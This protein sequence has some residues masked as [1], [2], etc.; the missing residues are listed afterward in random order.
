M[1]TNRFF[2]KDDEKEKEVQAKAAERPSQPSQPK[3][4]QPAAAAPA[5]NYAGVR[6]GARGKV[7]T[8][9]AWNQ[10]QNVAKTR[11]AIEETKYSVTERNWDPND[12]LGTRRYNARLARHAA[13][14]YTEQEKAEYRP[15]KLN[16][17]FR[18]V[19][20]NEQAVFFAASMYGKSK[21]QFLKDYAE[22]SG[23]NVQ[24]LYEL[25]DAQEGLFSD[26]LSTKEQLRSLGL[27]TIDGRRI[28]PDVD[29]PDTIVQALKDTADS[30]LQERGIKLL[31]YMTWDKN[32]RFYGYDAYN[33]D[34][35]YRDSAVLT[36]GDYDKWVKDLAGKF[37]PR[38]E[39]L[40]SS[41][42]KY[43]A[44]Y[45]ALAAQGDYI[46]AQ[47]APALEKAFMQQMGVGEMPGIEELR[48]QVNGFL[49][50]EQQAAREAQL[51]AEQD[52]TSD[53]EKKERKGFFDG[54][55]EGLAAWWG[56]NTT[57]ASD[58]EPEEEDEEAEEGADAPTGYAYGGGSSGGGSSSSG[59]AAPTEQEF[60]SRLVADAGANIAQVFAEEANRTL[61]VP[62]FAGEQTEEPI[63][64]PGA[65][66]AA[67]KVSDIAG[68]EWKPEL[69]NAANP[70][71]GS[72]NLVDNLN[73]AMRYVLKGK[74]GLL[75]AD[76]VKAL[77]EWAISSPETKA[78][79]GILDE[80]DPAVR[81]VAAGNRTHMGAVLDSTGRL[82]GF[83][84]Y[85]QK[86]MKMG[87]AQSMDGNGFMPDL[88]DS[89]AAA[90]IDAVNGM[91]S[92][93]LTPEQQA[94]VDGGYTTRGQI[95][96][97]ANPDVLATVQ[98]AFDFADSQ[99]TAML[100]A[101]KLAAE[102]S[103]QEA[104]AATKARL[105][106]GYAAEGDLQ[107]A[108]ANTPIRSAADRSTDKTYVEMA[109]ALQ[110]A[111]DA[112]GEQAWNAADAAFWTAFEGTD[113]GEIKFDWL[114]EQTL[115]Y[116]VANGL[117]QD[118]TSNDAANYR[119]EL[120]DYQMEALIA[121]DY[122]A[123]VYGYD[124]LG[125][126]WA[127]TGTGTMED[128]QASALALR[129]ADLKAEEE[130][131]AAEANQYAQYK[132]T[133]DV[134]E[135]T[136]AA[137][138]LMRGTTNNYQE[139]RK[140]L[141]H[142]GVVEDTEAE[143]FETHNYY[144]TTGPIATAEARAKRDVYGMIE[145]GYIPDEALAAQ[146][147]EYLD[148]GGSALNLAIMPR[149]LGWELAE[150]IKLTDARLKDLTAWELE[151]YTPGQGKRR[152]MYANVADNTIDQVESMLLQLPLMAVPQASGLGRFLYRT[153]AFS[154][155]YGA[156]TYNEGI[157]DGANM[158]MDPREASL[159][160][161]NRVFAQ[162]IVEQYT[163][164]KIASNVAKVMGV[165]DMVAA[166]AAQMGTTRAGRL[167]RA[168]GKALWETG[169]GAFEEAGHDEFFGK[170]GEK[171]ADAVTWK[172]IRT[173]NGL[174]EM[175]TM[176][177]LVQ[178]AGA[179]MQGGYE[180]IPEAY[181][182]VVD[183]FG[184][185]FI[186][187]IPITLLSGGA[188]GISDFRSSK[189]IMDAAATG[190]PE[191]VAN[192]GA[193]MVEVA[194]DPKKAALINA[195]AVEA[196]I[197]AVAADIE[198]HD[199]GEIGAKVDE[200]R[201]LK[202]QADSH[203]SAY[204]EARGRVTA[205]AK[206]AR[207]MQE[208]INNGDKSDA[209]QNALKEAQDLWNQ[210]KHVMDEKWA[211]YQEKKAESDIAHAEARAAAR[212]EAS[213]RIQQ[214]RAEL[215]KRITA[216]EKSREQVE[217]A[218]N[219]YREMR[220][221]V[222]LEA[223]DWVNENYADAPEAKKAELK[224]RY[225]DRAEKKLMGVVGTEDLDDTIE[226]AEGDIELADYYE[227]YGENGVSEEYAAQREEARGRLKQ[228]EQ[229][230]AVRYWL[231]MQDQE[232]YAPAAE[233]AQQTT[234]QADTAQTAESA[235]NQTTQTK[236]QELTPEERSRLINRDR[237]ARQIG[238]R[239]SVN[240]EFKDRNDPIMNGARGAYS[241]KNNTIYMA[242]DATQ[243]DIV[244]E[245]FVHELTHRAQES[246]HYRAM[247]DAILE[248]K[249]QG[250]KKARKADMESLRK[251][252]EPKYQNTKER[253]A[254]FK[255]N[256]G[257]ILEQELVARAAEELLAA[258][259]A[260]I[261]RIVTQKPTVARRIAD[262]LKGVLD[263][264]RGVRDPQ[265]DA[266]RRAEKYMRKALDEVER[267][268]RK[269]YRKA[270]AEAAHPNSVQF[271]VEQLAEAAGYTI[272][273][274]ETG[275]HRYTF[276]DRDGNEAHEVSADMLHDTPFGNL[277]RAAQRAG[278]IDE[279]TAQ[280]QFEGI[281]K[282]VN[283]GIKYENQ[284]MVWEIAG[285]QL[286]S[287]MKS[288]ADKQY[289]D[290]IDF[291]TI[292]AKTQ[293]LIDVLSETM[294][295]KGAGLSRQDVIDA[296]QK[297]S[298]V[299]FDVPCPVCYVFT[300]WMG[301]PNLLGNMAKWQDRFGGMSEAEVRTY[302]STVEKRYAKDGKT[303][304][305]GVDDA[306][307]S[308]GK[309][310]YD[311]TRKLQ[312]QLDKESDKKKLSP[313][314]LLKLTDELKTLEEQY[315]DLEC[316]NWVTQVLCDPNAR[317]DAGVSLDP[318]YEAVPKDILLD[319]NKTGEF[320]RYTKSWRYR[321]TRGAGMGKAILPYSGARI[322]DTVFGK[323]DGGRR[324]PT[325]KNVFLTGSEKDA[326]KAIRSAI[327]RLKA[328][329]LIGGQRF[330]STS[331]YR[332]EWGVDYM[333]TFLE[334]QAIG[335]KGQLYTKVIEAVDMFAKAGIEVNLSIMGKG[336]GYHLDENGNPA[337]NEDDFSSV[338]GI[339]YR[340]ARDKTKDY[341][342]VQMILVGL[343]DTHIRLAMASDEITFIIPWHSSGSS[344]AILSSLMK[345]VEED[346]DNSSDYTLWQ[347]DTP[348]EKPPKGRE[349]EKREPSKQQLAARD[350]RERII[351]GKLD[352]KNTR[353]KTGSFDSS[354]LSEADRATLSQNPWLADLYRRFYED[355]TAEEYGV[356]L[357]ASQAENIFPYEYWDRS[358][359]IEDADQNGKR[360]V[361]YCES[362][363]MT[364]R[365][366]KFKADKG[367][368]KLLIDRRMYDKKGSYHHP[369]TIGFTDVTL[370][371][372]A[373]SVGKVKYGDP[374][375]TE[376]AVQDTLSAID[377]RR[378]QE[379]EATQAAVDEAKAKL[380]EPKPKRTRKTKR[381]KVQEAIDE[382]RA[383]LP[384]EQYNE[385]PT[386]LQ[387]SVDE[388]YSGAPDNLMGF[389]SDGQ[390][391]RGY[392]EQ[393]YPM[394]IP[395]R[396]RFGDETVEDEIKGMNRAHAMERARRNWPDAD[397]IQFSVDDAQYALPS[398]D[399]LNQ[400][401]DAWID[402]AGGR[403]SAMRPA[404][405]G[406]R[407][408][409]TKTAQESDAL[410]DWV[411]ERLYNDPDAR[412]YMKDSNAAQLIRGHNM[413][414]RDGYI[415]TRD[416]LMKTERMS[417]DDVAASNIIM[418][419]A[420]REN[421]METLMLMA[422]R[423]DL[424]GTLLGQA[425][426][427]RKIF[428]SMSP[429]QLKMKMA[430][431]FETKTKEYM[432][433]HKSNTKA[434]KERAAKVSKQLES[435][436]GE[437]EILKLAQ[438]NY[439]IRYGDYD[440][441]WN[442]PLNERQKALIDKY[443]LKNVA[444]PGEHYNRATT[445]QRMLE[446]ILATPDPLAKTGLGLNLVDRLEMMK[447]KLPVITIADLAYIEQNM[448]TYCSFAD[449][450][451]AD[452]GRMGDLALSRV[453]EA[454]GNIDP[455]T[456]GEKIKTWGYVAM[457]TNLPSAAR[458]IVGNTSMN[459]VNAAADG[460]A[461][462]LDQ[463]T[464]ALLKTDR[465]RAHL[466][467]KQRAEGWWAFAE[468]TINT[469]RDYF[470]DK[471]IVQ[472]GN[473]KFDMNTRG[474]LYQLQGLEDLRLVEGFLMSV[475]DRNFWKK[476]FFNSISEQ[477]N[478]AKINGVE[479]DYEAAAQIA[480]NEAN[481]ATFTEDSDVIKALSMLKNA[482]GVGWA[483]HFAMPFTGVPTNILTR[484]I[485]Y[486]P[487]NLVAPF[488]KVLADKA[489]GNDFDQ[490]YFVDNLSKG[491]TGSA[492]FVIGMELLKMGLLHLGTSED[493][494]DLYYLNTAQG[495]QYT[496]YLQLG[497]RNISLSTFS[498]A[499]SALIA[500]GMF[501]RELGDNAAWYSAV[502]SACLESYDTILEASYL[503]GVADLLEAWKEDG[504]AGAGMSLAASAINMNIPVVLGQ[505]ADAFDPY[506]RDTK[507]ANALKAVY[508]SV[509]N[510][511]PF[512]RNK[513]LPAK[514]D[515]TGEKVKSKPGFSAL[516]QPLTITD[517]RNDE[518]LNELERIWR[519]VDDSI[520]IPGYLIPNSG[521]FKISKT[522]AD[523]M[524]GMDYEAGEH[525]LVLTSEQRVKYNQMYGEKMFDA[526]ADVMDS[527]DYQY[528]DDTEKARLL[529]DLSKTNGVFTKIKQEV[530]R[531][532]CID[533]GYDF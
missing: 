481:Y 455:A 58:A 119:A 346:I 341:D 170:I 437:D 240:I 356:S 489:A 219:A 55:K 41:L 184:T 467:A 293:A 188:A 464:S 435:M 160:A 422:H 304:K 155:A 405:L 526:I 224:R 485:Q 375:R 233:A 414:Q 373:G 232:Q 1:A 504:V 385:A 38:E 18:S 380:A 438:G 4:S 261:T 273:V 521:S 394:S 82:G 439:S 461:V 46:L 102:K 123:R 529:G 40:E 474:R 352:P 182:E 328:Q 200:A 338:T 175:P 472:N 421:D 528:G 235:P 245:I 107:F 500:G 181:R 510:R 253:S 332:P 159:L 146:M 409:A 532:I 59:A 441:K 299:G 351:T 206:T 189:A 114:N 144:F 252:Y 389:S 171:A 359:R 275:E 260:E 530:E 22:Y 383:T 110:Q 131:A 13:G 262:T 427:A 395:V 387:F 147:K 377:T 263:R 300:R 290:T 468:E 274:N 186:A 220:N 247:A 401:I 42:R 342:N 138:G 515:I 488:V 11:K 226:L 459:A 291:G 497:G 445:E 376:K 222:E 140:A 519:D 231:A 61:T 48:R 125:A 393:N 37:D 54:F 29:S 127:A 183:N 355:T 406:E 423:Y 122:K 248:W 230:K 74:G 225:S 431:K 150:D 259:E 280:K 208:K 294:L 26:K 314:E 318:A 143:W 24:T 129:E 302:V 527:S 369:R 249:Y 398:D 493:E 350:L 319:M 128:L 396:L 34:Y 277:I 221:A 6:S 17:D 211:E 447:A 95:Y 296:Y 36:K 313:K 237:F 153:M 198:L 213:K 297:T 172:M 420:E 236:K 53:G 217:K 336:N 115:Q 512:A 16:V 320:S 353:E 104:L 301:V 109:G 463:I 39:K 151:N 324:I 448:R 165:T 256:G 130:D 193:A 470:V 509:L 121:E 20:N 43:L 77:D 522:V 315:E 137:L 446:A 111:F 426:Q 133:G 94:L 89:A 243:A 62:A 100:K 327:K 216:E 212:A 349:D 251:V 533:L 3:T 462:T 136:V 381:D 286:F 416:R 298:D 305:E 126:M 158:N 469:F 163:D 288:N 106:S 524:Y 378:Q 268:R 417:E 486:S 241:K 242:S 176:A 503:S 371:D 501:A 457:L 19:K 413:I 402:R 201:K 93:E 392:D 79:L 347:S 386:D 244:K 397:D 282:L 453:Y 60:K 412:F 424:D 322:G 477:M 363:G 513:M 174:T 367:Y 98:E 139:L 142:A 83:A 47:K 87:K 117:E 454:Y 141:A 295:R 335:A 21:K 92:M 404:T 333:M 5:A 499:A 215:A 228:A 285:E 177:E 442:V 195:A 80:S 96:S 204:T 227:E 81:E 152:D 330:Q 484:P 71:P 433:T 239:H 75:D 64:I 316:Y 185:N 370:G 191:A 362:L 270:T 403:E 379:A 323:Q 337:L 505:L 384:P 278:T 108:E 306:K 478:L 258:D 187:S 388:P 411:K 166:G 344:D 65:K 97:D 490:R 361:E 161:K 449:A 10:T 197:S 329:N 203:Q 255:K 466:T 358:L 436:P 86:L 90:L 23:Q 209:T 168:V 88:Y 118:L 289:G 76:T 444:R 194:R 173:S 506:T 145:G 99:Y 69:S 229:Q 460:V 72:V 357:S 450:T 120:F 458:N 70:Q 45:D 154:A 264:V 382:A 495:E 374:V 63:W 284:A 67:T 238:R 292:C 135:G 49:T 148:N 523:E 272:R 265:I 269:E 434:I 348:I 303:A 196:H 112:S 287:A 250:N 35:T 364:P 496:A 525:K 419:M 372:V 399:L 471:A 214:Q 149:K 178:I 473:E 440:N 483:V 281:A 50:P 310:L 9:K 452:A 68:P 14:I 390:P 254:E 31:Q 334:M 257:T 487:V 162:S 415:E 508:K 28:D 480:I 400:Q 331:D 116:L 498:P 32:S 190:S 418:M 307:T 325:D 451:D 428:S 156:R 511:I 105:R 410:P 276:I 360:F 223:E 326:D 283:L 482:K 491:M 91:N 132:G 57:A 518:T 84:K 164:T 134:G 180:A 234:Q 266:M 66:E 101:E 340:Q 430:G 343:N 279:A 408:F 33:Q 465:T 368:W 456:L 207:E 25:A 56:E 311:K 312:D 30:D 476:K 246:G 429:T 475:G 317:T 507:D 124:D 517:V 51:Q 514:V 391:Q 8:Q 365:F 425:M 85:A 366:S 339:D 502:A 321:T 267:K 520:K 52:G 44:E 199:T 205:A 202:Q 443:G 2:K 12:E 354:T 479:F 516:W 492:L 308:I 169:K 271:S 218:E 192:A 407:Q 309:K 345:A 167:F 432:E 179:A 15:N 27:C 113:A 78:F 103:H 7:V 73:E 157:T 494:D 531:Q 210:A